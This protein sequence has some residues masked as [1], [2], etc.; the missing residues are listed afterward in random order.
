MSK[1]VERFVVD[2]T[3]DVITWTA[4]KTSEA[5]NTIIDF[6]DPEAQWRYVAAVEEPFFESVMA[7]FG[8]PGYYEVELVCD[9]EIE[10]SADGIAGTFEAKKDWMSYTYKG[11]DE[12][13]LFTCTLVSHRVQSAQ[14]ALVNGG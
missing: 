9:I 11:N 13:L 8:D 5:F 6:T 14:E 7:D 10:T 1:T 2:T 12:L 3:N 4:V